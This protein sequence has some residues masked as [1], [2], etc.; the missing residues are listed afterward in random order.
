MKNL[1]LN[2]EK[3]K[4]IHAFG[5]LAELGQEIT[6]RGSFPETMRTSLH[7]VSGTLGFMR[8]GGSKYSRFARELNMVA[9]RGLGDEFPLALGLCDEDER[10][11][12]TN[13]LYPIDVD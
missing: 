2:A 10:Q 6:V 4:L 3:N 13:G 12:L 1:I 8:G 5:A 9:A 7:L 11:F